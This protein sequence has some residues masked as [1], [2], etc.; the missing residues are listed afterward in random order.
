MRKPEPGSWEHLRNQYIVAEIARGVLTLEQIGEETGLTRQ[1]V[2]QI[3]NTVGVNRNY[4]WAPNRPRAKEMRDCP[5]CGVR[6]RKVDYKQHRADAGH[7]LK[8]DGRLSQRDVDL[9]A[10]YYDLGLGYKSLSMVFGIVATDIKYHLR[11]RGVRFHPLGR[12]PGV[13]PRRLREQLI[14][15]LDEA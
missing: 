2:A 14:A 15:E 10:K 1:R 8:P 3:G 7:P 11:K 4:K 6:L 5:D 12:V 9:L 13:S